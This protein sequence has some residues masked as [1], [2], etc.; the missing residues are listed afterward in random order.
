MHL[1]TAKEQ[2]QA[3]LNIKEHLIDGGKREHSFYTR[4]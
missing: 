2:Q 3:L 4:Q 1:L